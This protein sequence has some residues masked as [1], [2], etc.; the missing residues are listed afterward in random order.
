[1][2]NERFRPGGTLEGTP[3]SMIVN[4]DEMAVHYEQTATTTIASTNSSS[5]AI[6]G[7]GSNSQRLTACITCAQDGTKLPLFLVFKAK[8]RGTIEKKL[9]KLLPL[10]VL[11][12]PK[13]M[14]GCNPSSLLLLDEFKSHIQPVF[15]RQLSDLG[16]DLNIIPGGYT[17]VLQP[18]DVGVNKPIKEAVR[19]QYDDWAAEKMATI[20]PDANV[21]VPK[22]EDIVP[23][24]VRAWDG[25]TEQSIRNTFASIG[26]GVERID[27]EPVDE[28]DGEDE[29]EEVQDSIRL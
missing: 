25:I 24:I 19:A 14:D 9:D 26:F 12:A 20:P 4:M 28:S 27:T 8:P 1:M 3:P 10:V 23:W 21:P 18:C 11:A 29:I 7:S 13:K 17:S 16:T 22:R 6:R 5:V 15:G 2:V